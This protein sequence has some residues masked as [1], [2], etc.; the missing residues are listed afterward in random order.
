MLHDQAII[1]L[2]GH[3]CSGKT[4]LGRLLASRLGA[5]YIK[6]FSHN[7]GDLIVWAYRNK[8]YNLAN[9]IAHAA[10]SRCVA[11]N[12]GVDCLVFDRHWLCMFTVL[13]ECFYA[14][15]QPLPFTI[16]CWADVENTERRMD[17]RGEKERYAGWNEHFCKIYVDLAKRFNVPIINTS[18]HQNAEEKLEEIVRYLAVYKDSLATSM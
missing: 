18:G 5:K 14:S 1:V 16:L 15:W 13:P 8:R 10:V 6:P 12:V 17:E 7:L 4:T 9:D 3:D 2:D 11:E